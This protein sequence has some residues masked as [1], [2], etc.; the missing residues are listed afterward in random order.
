MGGC[1]V[2]ERMTDKPSTSQ[3]LN[4]EHTGTLLMRAGVSGIMRVTY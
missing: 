1:V 4:P 3:K 2:H